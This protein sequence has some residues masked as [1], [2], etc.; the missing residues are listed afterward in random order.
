MN[1]PDSTL[2]VSDGMY[3]LR[4]Q[5]LLLLRRSARAASTVRTLPPNALDHQPSWLVLACREWSR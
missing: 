5:M 1:L 2:N 3:E 4:T